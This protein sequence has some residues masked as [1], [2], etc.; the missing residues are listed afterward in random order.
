MFTFL[1][2]LF[3]GIV[4]GIAAALQAPFS[5]IMGQKLDDMSSVFIT[6]VGGALL[7][8]LITLFSGGAGLAEWRSLPW[9]VFLAGPLGLVII[10]ALSYTV[11]RLGTLTATTLFV[12][13]W[14]ICSAI[15]DHFGWFGL[16]SR[17]IDLGRAGG[18]GALI[19]GTW[20]VIR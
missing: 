10:G 4:G 16:Q 14:L 2:Q 8:S 5:G 17:P 13:A 15:I 3:V 11:P 9:Y 20:L 7:I 18:V 12:L 1:I 19:I 6:Y